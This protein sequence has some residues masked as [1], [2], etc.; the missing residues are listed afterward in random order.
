VISFEN[1]VSKRE[2]LKLNVFVNVELVKIYFKTGEI[3]RILVFRGSH[4]Q[5][6]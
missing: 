2:Y 1:F 3:G 5:Y 4:E 6:H